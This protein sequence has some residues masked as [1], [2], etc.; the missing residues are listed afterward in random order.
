M[1]ATSTSNT[2]DCDAGWKPKPASVV[3][4][5]FIPQKRCHPERSWA[6]FLRPTESKD[7]RLHFGNHATNFRLRT[8]ALTLTNAAP[9]DARLTPENLSTE[10]TFNGK[11]AVWHPGLADPA[12]LQGTTHT[13]DGALGLEDP[14]AERGSFVIVFEQGAYL[15]RGVQP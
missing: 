8:L 5:K 7:L 12:N 14:R 15:L 4:Q 2:G 11:S 13:L 9:G 3:S 10:L 6:R 1:Y